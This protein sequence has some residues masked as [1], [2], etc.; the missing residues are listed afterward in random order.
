MPFF[1]APDGVRLYYETVGS[2]PPIVLQ[3]GGAGDGSMWRDAGY[4]DSL[5][6]VRQCLLFDHRGHGRSDQPPLAEA[7]T[8]QRYADDVCALLDHSGIERTAFWGYSQGAEIGLA[9]A[10]LHPERLES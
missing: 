5:S 9:V 10:A 4:V 7:H 6:M 1:V 2:G 3:T 8:M